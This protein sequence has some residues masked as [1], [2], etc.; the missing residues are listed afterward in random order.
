M[1]K[2]RNLII[3]CAFLATGCK[4]QLMEESETNLTLVELYSTPQGL[5]KAMT[6][7]YILEQRGPRDGAW[8]DGAEMLSVIG[9]TDI[10]VMNGGPGNGY[11]T[12]DPIEMQNGDGVAFTCGSFITP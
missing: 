12:Y 9:G 3:L 5:D 7:L 2:I 8:W 4:D 6:G 10:T 1:R 11:R